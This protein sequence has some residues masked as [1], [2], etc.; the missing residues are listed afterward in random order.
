MA[1]KKK[2]SKK[3]QPLPELSPSEMNKDDDDLMND[4]LA[5]LDSRDQNVQQQSAN[6]LNDM[7]LNAKAVQI[8]TQPKQDAKSRFKARQVINLISNITQ[9]NYSFHQTYVG[10][11]GCSP[12]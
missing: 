6:L 8:E 9:F 2:K 11:K 10:E 7:D 4:L 1:Q 5:Q 12:G 3:S